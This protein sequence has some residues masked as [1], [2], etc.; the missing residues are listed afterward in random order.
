MSIFHDFF[1]FFLVQCSSTE[2]TCADGRKCIPS[3]YKCDD[4]N[5][6]GDN[7][8]ERNCPGKISVLAS[9]AQMAQKQKSS[10]T[11]S[12]SMQGWVFRLGFQS[13][14]FNLLFL[15]VLLLDR[16]R[17]ET[18]N[19]Q[20]VLTA[21]TIQGRNLCKDGDYSRKHGRLYAKNSTYTQKFK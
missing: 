21:E 10:A 15:S 12:P 5:D 16:I 9:L 18:I 13:S 3:S 11:K 17:E 2:F 20:E 1:S 4:D 14:C 7:S 19:Y 8:D 6:C